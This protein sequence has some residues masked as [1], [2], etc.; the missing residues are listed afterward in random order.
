MSR[1]IGLAI[2]C[3][4]GCFSATTAEIPLISTP[5]LDGK[6]DDS[7]W[8]EAWHGELIE[9]KSGK[10]PAN[11]THVWLG[12]DREYLYIAFECF[13]T[14]VDSIRKQ[15][16]HGE[17]RDNA[18]FTD[19]CV[20][21]FLDPFGAGGRN[22]YHFAVNSSG[23]VYDALA[24]DATYDSHLKAVSR[25]GSDRWIAEVAIPF[26]DLGINPGGAELLRISLGRERPRSRREDSCLKSGAGGFS[27]DSRFTAFQPAAPD[28]KPSSLTAELRFRDGK[29]GGVLTADRNCRATLEFLDTSRRILRK[30]ELELKPGSPVAFEY[31]GPMSKRPAF[32]RIT[33][34]GADG[35]R[36]YTNIFDY[37]E[38]GE[39]LRRTF[40][41]EK[42]LYETLFGT[43][44]KPD[45]GFAGFQ[46]MHGSGIDGEMRMF[47]LQFG[48][49]YSGEAFAGEAKST[50][51]ASLTNSSRVEYAN[52]RS[53]CEK[54]DIPLLVL[55]RVKSADVKS[56]LSYRLLVVPE[57][58]ALYLAEVERGVKAAP[59]V[60][61]LYLGDEMSEAN[62][63]ELILAFQKFPDKPELRAIDTEIKRKYGQG[64][65][66]IPTSLEEKNP[67]AWIA[68]R[69]WLNDAL[70]DLFHSAYR[71][72]KS[73][74]PDI[75][76]VSDDPTARR[77]FLYAFSD[78]PGSFDI[79]THQ[80]YPRNNPDL[81]N[82]GFITKYLTDL[83]GAGNVWPCAHVEEYGASFSPQEVLDK[84]SAAVRCGATGFH[85]YLSDTVG[86]RAG[87]KYLVHE[88]F[89]A[90]DRYQAEIAVQKELAKR[91]RLAFPDA[92]TAIFTATDSLRAYP[93]PMVTA[94]AVTS[95]LFLHGYLS[96]SIGVWYKFINEQTLQNLAPYRLIAAAETEYIDK[97]TLA[98]LRQYVENGGTLLLLNPFSFS[99]TPEGEELRMAR[100]A[101]T[102]IVC[103]E[104]SA[105]VRE[106]KYRGQML[107]V[108]GVP[109][110]VLTPAPGAKVTGWLDN[111]SPGVIEYAL[112]RGKVI[113]LAFNPCQQRLAGNRAW[114]KFFRTIATEAGCRTD[115]DIWRFQLPDTL[116]QSPKPPPGRCLTGNAVFWNKFHPSMPNNIT[117]GG[118]YT[119]TPPP[120]WIQDTAPGPISF[121][122]GKLTD[123][124]RAV[125]A[126]SA[127][128]GK[129]KWT[130]WVV[131]YRPDTSF[132]VE[133][134]FKDF[135][136]VKTVKFWIWG[137]WRD[138][139]VIAGG[140]TFRFPVAPADVGS[141]GHDVHEVTLQLPE[142]VTT[143]VLT[144]ETAGM[145][146]RLAIA[147]ME[148]WGP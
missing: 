28:R 128:L 36:L 111:G 22:S 139:V 81:D 116:I 71:L 44:R 54:Y 88:Y 55:P 18:I 114:G 96:R 118:T 37:P 15:F 30:T 76:V 65:Y 140:K 49:S 62:E 131:G 132:R 93:G 4:M 85:Y 24:G 32:L 121:E 73:V 11:P 104:P 112:G 42:P 5:L 16:T 82:F 134:R 7:G 33:V 105:S 20:E 130:D 34:T 39:N 135:R 123:R 92:D 45:F 40:R 148:V 38:K 74:N 144:V 8:K 43:A 13:E 52:I 10:R 68:Y 89:G 35:E 72:A 84:L 23:V 26:S 137:I 53:H 61:G 103:A 29:P 50:G 124:T 106:L 101:M 47:A 70:V 48:L 142:T 122:H 99:R 126:P 41:V 79:V 69:R 1:W 2:L 113:T 59:N 21:I 57:V 66:G 147:E 31:N 91:P 138:T 129:S 78:W 136:P 60:K 63:K 95:D 98:V 64:K 110:A 133:I 19:D 67:L 109:A 97:Q 107:P 80:L 9:L 120:N 94:G 51:M 100:T 125:T 143:N 27:D 141:F 75:T 117:T 146:S 90:P 3:W 127:Q 115:Q 108:R 46:W 86:R 87:K 6:L 83:T 17:E 12:R 77:N 25:I 14:D 102:G 58:R 145:N 119:L 56:G